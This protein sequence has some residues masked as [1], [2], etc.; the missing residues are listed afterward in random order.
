MHPIERLRWIA[1]A[2]DADPSGLALEAVSALHDLSRDPRALVMAAKRLV[3]SHP[4]CGPLWWAVSRMLVAYDPREEAAILAE[5][6]ADDGT[7]EELAASF[8]SAALVVGEPGRYIVDSLVERPDVTARLVG[9][10]WQVGSALRELAGASDVSGWAVDEAREALVGATVCCVEALAAGPAGAIV[11]RPAGRLAEVA[12]ASAVPVWL[13]AGV[14]RVLPAALF[15]A[16]VRRS[17]VSGA[18]G[19]ALVDAADIDL[20]VGLDGAM[21]AAQGLS[22]GDGPVA[23]ELTR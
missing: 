17:S 8:P 2:G 20:F 7:A 14:G 9:E 1:G 10:A 13:V 23:L 5:Q 11:Q 18:L 21:P 16:V 4:E 6:L 19:V 12:K 22:S 3:S 15:D